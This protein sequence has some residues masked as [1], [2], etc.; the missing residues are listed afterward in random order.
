MALH[1]SFL[2][3]SSAIVRGAQAQTIV[4]AFSSSEIIRHLPKSNNVYANICI[5]ICSITIYRGTE[6]GC[7][8]PLKAYA[9]RRFVKI[10][11][12]GERTVST[13]WAVIIR[14]VNHN[15]L[16]LTWSCERTSRIWIRKPNF[17]AF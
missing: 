3:F 9:G 17:L 8:S 4:V 1:S 12:L 7:L 14:A 10:A 16:K 15:N 5:E 6:V 13:L 11:Q 2:C